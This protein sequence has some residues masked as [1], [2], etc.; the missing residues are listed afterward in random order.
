[1]FLID[2]DK[3]LGDVD[4]EFHNPCSNWTMFLIGYYGSSYLV[5]RS[6]NPYFNWTMFL[7][8]IQYNAETEVLEFQS[9][10]L[11]DNVSYQKKS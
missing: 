6:F 5:N 8:K 11:L 2:T 9:L 1:M 3:M 4:I 10:L 7:M